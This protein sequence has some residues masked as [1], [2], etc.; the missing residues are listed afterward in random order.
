MKNIGVGCGV[1][2]LNNN[3]I[4]LGLRNSDPLLADCDLHEEDNWTMPG[5]SIN[6]N[7]SFEDA[8]IRETKEETDLDIKD[9]KVI[10]VQVDKNEFAHYV[11]VG[12][13]AK[14]FSGEVKVMEP[15]EIIKWEWFDINSLPSN[16]FSASRKTIDCYLK[17]KFY[18]KDDSML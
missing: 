7:E 3:K 15:N 2:I 1:I 13:I 18:I 5:G 11:S 16:I 17:N 12:M 4:L 10:C 6:Y 14:N 8:G 9:P